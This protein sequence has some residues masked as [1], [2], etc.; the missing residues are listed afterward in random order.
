MK[1]LFVCLGNI[2][3]SAAAEAVMKKLA[4]EQG[5]AGKFQIDSAGLI[6]YHEGEPAD[7]RMRAHA[8]RRGYTIDS[9]SRP[10]RTSDFYDFDLII[11]M[12]DRN[13]DELKR[14]APDL[15]TEKKIHRMTE[16]ASSKL[17]DHVPD[18]YYSGAEGFELVLD[19]LEDACKGLLDHC[20]AATQQAK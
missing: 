9:I 2:C 7:P 16:Y 19:L 14:K 15:N 1:L 10:V 4:T 6:N 18:P 20:I 8:A 12:D 3:R 5:V 13:I 17:Y 11:G